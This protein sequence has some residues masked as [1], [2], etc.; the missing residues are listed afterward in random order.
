MGVYPV[1]RTDWDLEIELDRSGPSSHPA[2]LVPVPELRPWPLGLQLM[3]E[4][5]CTGA[6]AKV[7]REVKVYYIIVVS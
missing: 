5:E 1:R 4:W 3:P 2:V 7:G 6:L